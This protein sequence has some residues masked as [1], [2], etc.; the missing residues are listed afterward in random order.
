MRVF[1][2]FA[3]GLLVHHCLELRGSSYLCLLSPCKSVGIMGMFGFTS[4]LGIRTHTLT[5]AWQVLYSLYQPLFLL[6]IE[7]A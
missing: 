2:L 7:S 4:V 3:S 6:R 1:T 5:L